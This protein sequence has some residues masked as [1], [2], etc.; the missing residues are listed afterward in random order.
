MSEIKEFAEKL[1]DTA[2][3][4]MGKK[5]LANLELELLKEIARQIGCD[6]SEDDT[7]DS[8]V[9]LLLKKKRN[10]EVQPV[11]SIMSPSYATKETVLPGTS[12]FKAKSKLEVIAFNSL[13]LRVFREDLKHQFQQLVER[14][15]QAD[16]ILMSEVTSVE[17][18]REFLSYLN[19]HGE[20]S[21]H[22]SQSSKPSNEIHAVFVKSHLM[23]IRASTTVSVGLHEF[24]HAPFTILLEDQ[25]L[26]RFV[27]S[28]VHFPPESKARERD[29]EIKAFIRAYACE[30]ALR[31]D[32][33]FTEKGA[34]DS[35]SKL[36]VHVIAG[37]FN[38]WVGH[39]MYEAQNHGFYPL[40][41]K[42]ISTTSGMRSF[43]N[44]LITHYA[45]DNF[46]ISSSV[47]EL[48]VPQKSCKGQIGLSDHSP[49]ALCV[50]RSR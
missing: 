3:K 7:L 22:T 9:K 26:G 36:P 29:V 11:K 39:D 25:R 41:G 38:T 45:K 32:T 20:W 19:G 28:S 23:V 37:D 4:G 18:A 6:T 35:R 47:L 50:E 2:L 33:P 14:F 24:A 16:V 46:T 13:K 5:K 15:V 31:C 30:A 34:K 1:V 12:V 21:L 49:I 48:E 44:M 40:I 10:K 42:N 43:D 8:M 17:R 27:L